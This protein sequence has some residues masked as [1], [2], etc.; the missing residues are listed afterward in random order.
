ML[1]RAIFQIHALFGNRHKALDGYTLR[2]IPGHNPF[3]VDFDIFVFTTQGLHLLDDAVTAH[4]HF[5]HV[6]TDAEP[7]LLG[8]ECA[9]WIRD[10]FGSYDYYFYLED[11]LLIHDPMFLLK[12][13]AFNRM[14]AE[15]LPDV[16][17]QPQ[18]YELALLAYDRA[19][20]ADIDKLYIDYQH[21]GLM[22]PSGPTLRM[23][24]LGIDIVFEPARNPHAGCYMISNAQAERV[25]RH[26]DFLKPS[27]IYDAPGD[28][29]ATG[30]ILQALRVY[31]PARQSLA[32]LEVQH[33]HQV[34]LRMKES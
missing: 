29:A 20:L 2:L 1:D 23:N 26:P 7:P 9:K 4:R 27:K 14:A 11:D 19:V 6:E 18:R 30:F 12:I 16:M 34:C 13:D 28:T 25:I 8:F 15:Q 32:F 5:T 24:F 17:L 31:K 21:S 10:H 33:G 22:V 3:A